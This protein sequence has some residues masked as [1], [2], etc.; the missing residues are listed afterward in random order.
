MT[1]TFAKTLLATSIVLACGLNAAHAKDWIEKVDIKQGGID[2]VPV[3]IRSN[4]IKY[5]TTAKPTHD[6]KLDFYAKAESASFL[7]LRNRVSSRRPLVLGERMERLLNPMADLR[8]L[9]SY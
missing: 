3:N 8:V 9:A 6:F 5:T 2:L 1:Q 4:G 7:Q